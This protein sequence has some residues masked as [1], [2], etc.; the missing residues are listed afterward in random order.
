MKIRFTGSLVF[1]I[2]VAGIVAMSLVTSVEWSFATRLFPWAMGIPALIL[3]A[4]QLFLEVRKAQGV[5]AEDD[6]SGVMDLTVDRAV[7]LAQV[8][9]RGGN[10]FAW[11][12]GL[13]ASI[14][15]IGFVITAPL[16]IWL[17][18]TIQAREKWWI[19]LLC[20]A[21][22]VVFLLGLFHFILRVPWPHGIIELPQEK[23]LEWI[24]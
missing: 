22:I 10:I 19:S 12:F 21:V 1:A 2:F 18:L 8:V 15:L 4:V 13:F 9:R 20:T 6:N 7:P 17:Y 16:F 23:M 5:A 11:I 14:M 3:C 24:G